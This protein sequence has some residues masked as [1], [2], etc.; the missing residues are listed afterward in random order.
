MRRAAAYVDYPQA[1]PLVFRID[2][3]RCIGCGVCEGEC[4]A[5]AVRYDEREQELT[6]SVGAVILSPGFDE[7][8]PS[9]LAQYGHRRYPNVVTSIE[10][11]RLLSATGPHRGLVLRPSDGDIP[12]KVAFIQCVGSRDESI[13]AGFCSS[14]CCMYSLKEAVI[15]KEH[16]PGLAPHI[17]FMDVRAF[18][19]EFED[20][21]RRARDEVGVR[22]TR[23]ARPPAVEE[24]AATHDLVLVYEEGGELRQEEFGM[25]VL[26][27]GLHPPSSARQLGSVFGIELDRYGFAATGTFSP[28]ETSRPGIFVAGAFS[29]PKDIPTTVAEASGAAA[30]VQALLA[31]ARGTLV[32]QAEF[33]PEVD[34]AGQEPRIG[35]FVCHCGINIGGVVDVP[36]VVA[37]ARTLP[38]VAYA[39]DNLYTCSQDTQERIKQRIH[40]HGLNRVIVASCTPRTHEPLFQ[41]TVREGGL[42]KYLFEMANIRDQC[43]WT[44]MHIPVQATAKAKDLVRMAV[45]RARSLEPLETTRTPMTKAALVLGGGASGMTAALALADQGFRCFLVERERALGGNLARM[46]AVVTGEDPHT[47]L[48]RLVSAVN[49]HPDIAVHVGAEVESITG[50]VGNFR[51]V[52]RGRDAPLEHGVVIVA[53]GGTELRPEGLYLY[54]QDDRTKTQLE[55]EQELSESGP[56][57]P[58]VMIQCVGS[59]SEGRPYCSRVCCTNAVKNAIRVKEMDGSTPVTILYRDLR[60]YGLREDWYRRACELGVRFVRFDDDRPPVARATAK[61]IE[62]TVEDMTLGESLLFTA[63]RLVLSAAILPQPDNAVVAQMLKVPLSKDGF[64][65]EAHMK[66]RPVDFATEGVFLAGLAHWPKSIDESIAQA[67]GAAARAATL[68]SKDWVE[69]E[70]IVSSVDPELCRGCGRCEE[71]CEYSAIAVEDAEE[72]G[73]GVRVARVNEGLCKGCGACSVACPTRAV[74]MR[75]FTNEQIV[76]MLEALMQGGP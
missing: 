27:V 66:L 75:H 11:E 41:N 34:V 14:V 62:V 65:L 73:P 40:E 49:H 38:G 15:A 16:C 19:K 7:F 57:G 25:V 74:T 64:F 68:L 32:A 70:G 30:K 23:H 36:S 13:G 52:L 2:R 53:T 54:G 51:T 59:R 45:A 29:G 39:E 61:G 71:V 37:Y 21:V 58:V 24:V 33:P 55:F 72:L 60:T 43:S 12:G 17:F 22:I 28:L 35:V 76:A 46:R 67:C 31:A 8:D 9:V 4:R 5:K 26:A 6:L 10:F 47:M 48:E 44:H 18:G 56:T 42:N 3:S 69:A 50:Y 1:V 63:E 20:Y